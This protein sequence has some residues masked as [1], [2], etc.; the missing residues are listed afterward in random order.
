M[1]GPIGAVIGAYGGAYVGAKAASQFTE[2]LTESIFDLPKSE[3]EEK[4]YKFFELD[5][6]APDGEINAAYRRKAQKYHPDNQESGNHEKF[7][8]VNVQMQILRMAKGKK[9]MS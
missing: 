2:Y 6:H 9:R 5:F 8:E 1:F 3:A 4:A 7:F